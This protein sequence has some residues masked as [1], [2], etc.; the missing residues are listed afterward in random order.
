MK[1]DSRA[2]G[3]EDRLESFMLYAGA[4]DCS[5]RFPV[6]TNGAHI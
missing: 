1:T 6:T 2:V 3:D 4:T 5:G